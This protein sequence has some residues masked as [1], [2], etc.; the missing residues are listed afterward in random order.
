[1]KYKGREQSRNIIDRRGVKK[2]VTSDSKERSDSKLATW[3]DANQPSK[4]ASPFN[5]IPSNKNIS[6]AQRGSR[7]GNSKYRTGG[8][9]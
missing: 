2:K 7:A 3:L 1:M 9:V 8:G 4:P 6:K 5:R